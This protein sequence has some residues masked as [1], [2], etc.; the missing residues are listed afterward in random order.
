MNFSSRLG[1]FLYTIHSF[2]ETEIAPGY[3]YAGEIRPARVVFNI[4]Q[5]VFSFDIDLDKDV[6]VIAPMQRGYA[7]S[8]DTR[9]PFLA[10]ENIDGK[11]IFT[12]TMNRVMPITA[13][14]RRA[15]YLELATSKNLVAVTVNHDTGDNRGADLI[16]LVASSDIKLSTK[17]I[18]PP[19]P[20]A[21]I[22]GRPSHVK[23]HSLATG[24]I[25]GDSRD[26]V[27]IGDW[28]KFGAYAFLQNADGTF[29]QY[30]QALFKQIN[31]LNWPM[32]NPSVGNGWNGL[33]DLHLFDF[34][35]DGF[36]DLVSGWG[37]G[38][39]NSR[40]FI[41]S[42]GTYLVENSITIPT[43]IY[44]RDNQ[45]HLKT[46][47]ADFDSDG[48]EDLLIL[49]SRFDPYYG[50]HYLQYLKNDSG[51]RFVDETLK[52]FTEP[53]ENAY[54]G[55][56][57]WSD[58]W[59]VLDVNGDNHLDI[60]GT[61]ADNVFFK[62]TYALIFLNNTQGKF[63][64]HVINT[65]TNLPAPV[66]Q[67]G[68]FNKNGKVEYVT[69]ERKFDFQNPL[70]ADHF[71]KVYEVQDPLTPNNR[72]FYEKTKLAFDI[73]GNAGKVAKLL[74]VTFG[75]S[76]LTNREYV[77]AGLSLLDQG[78]SYQD[79]AALAVSVTKKSSTTDIC[80]LLW[81]NIFGKVPTA[82]DI[83]PYKAMLDSGQMSIGALTALAADTSFNS[84]NIDLVGL[85][86]TGL[87]YV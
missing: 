14:A 73:N 7:S 61:S 18:F 20:S 23:A 11:L 30:D 47:S 48:F 80:N 29:T 64:T 8:I 85:S 82:A 62:P 81:T 75:K 53:Y 56:L 17:T 25:N 72:I 68:D 22:G 5:A 78:M 28:S 26:D 12:E 43:S 60:V 46:F 69:F 24:D 57:E 3:E 51:K 21:L 15:D 41:N 40:L 59:Q 65:P 83:A 34:N 67:W 38:S 79:L 74:G 31:N 35:N 27:L 1:T 87:E 66:I 10:F 39:T 42:Q 4:P 52:R 45:Q 36:D 54:K 6:D 86:R 13:G 58:Y 19:T 70:V 77:G 33:L 63:T 16:G 84:T 2:K 55:S 50:G 76:A 9:T 37:G 49:W 71:F 32:D 44:G